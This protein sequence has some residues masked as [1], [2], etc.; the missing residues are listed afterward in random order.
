MQNANAINETAAREYAKIAGI[1]AGAVIVVSIPLSL[2]GALIASALGYDAA[3]VV[4]STVAAAI[5]IAA[6]FGFDALRVARSLIV[7]QIAAHL[8][9]H[10]AEAKRTNAEA[11]RILA[12]ADRID[13]ESAAIKLAAE[14]AGQLNV[15]SGPGKMTIKNHPITYRVNGQIVNGNQ[16]NQITPDARQL[17][18]EG[19]DVL[20]FVEQLAN[21][22]PHSKSKWV[23]KQELPYSRLP[24]TYEIYKTL[25]DSIAEAGGIVGRGERASG[26]LIE[27]HAPQLVKMIEATYPDAGREGITL[28]LPLP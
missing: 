2:A 7:N 17:H 25:V 21:G 24:V 19:A 8:A 28:E 6:L 26:R 11:E 22:Y 12:E 15:N 5:I 23:G 18:I 3:L 14:N 27:S 9:R 4:G 20:W 10:R 13:A 1:A 16:L